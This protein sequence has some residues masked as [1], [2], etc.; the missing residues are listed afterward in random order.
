MQEG[1]GGD[2]VRERKRVE[3]SGGVAA[4]NVVL[5]CDVDCRE[6]DEIVVWDRTDLADEQLFCVGP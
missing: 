3:P 4:E 1:V 6:V 2:R 5:L